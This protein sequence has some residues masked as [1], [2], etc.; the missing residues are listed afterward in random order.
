VA[1]RATTNPRLPSF[2][3]PALREHLPDLERAFDA[4]R[5]LRGEGVKERYL[6]QEVKEPLPAYQSRLD[7][8]VFADFFYDSINAFTGILSKFS[9]SL[10]LPSMEAAVDNIDREG[11]SLTAWFQRADGRMLRDG[12]VLLRVEM[13]PGRSANAAEEVLS[14]KRPYLVADNR[15]RVI[16][17]R[18]EQTDGIEQ[19]LWVIIQE[20]S[21]V[22]DGDFGI[23]PVTRY[24]QIGRGWWKLWEI[25]KD[26][27]G[28]DQAWE[29]DNG[30]YLDH[31]QKPLPIVPVVWYRADEG[32]GFGTGELPL[33]QVVE[34]VIEHFLARSD[35]NEKR[36]RCSMPVPWVRGRMPGPPMPDGTPSGPAPLVLGPNTFIELQDDGAFGFGEPSA[37]SLADQRQGV[38]DVEQLISRQTLGFLWGDSNGTKT[39]TQAGLEGAQTES[40]IERLASR[41]SSAMQRLM[42][43]WVMYTG[44][45]LE[46]GAGLSMSSTLFERP[47]EAADVAELQKL[48]G[49]VE[50]ISKRSAIEELQRRGKI[51]VTTSVD[52]EL[53]RLVD[54]T[55]EPA[56]EPDRNDLGEVEP[57]PET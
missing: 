14:G 46:P 3:H 55:P 40:V 13:P 10:P 54:E 43:I 29:V 21:E 8:S 27:V 4:Y 36:R 49:G 53:Q 48:A 5:R 38:L 32:T 57:E 17:W 30:E 42:E 31:T 19:L 45:T 12:G 47:M 52:E 18:T 33:R 34:H 23:K 2:V 26:V 25:D 24:R 50:L 51:R 22:P 39:A 11:N 7:R 35:L 20:E 16:N 56:E 28:E 9:L 37:S 6:P 41:K 1:T 15:A 44:E